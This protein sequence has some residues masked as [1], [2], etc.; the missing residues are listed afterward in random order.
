MLFPIRKTQVQIIHESN[1]YEVTLI[2]ICREVRLMSP[3]TLPG[4]GG[5]SR[6]PLRFSE[7]VLQSVSQ[8]VSKSSFVFV[9]SVRVCLCG[10]ELPGSRGAADSR[11]LRTAVQLIK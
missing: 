4:E 2:P 10:R 6:A 1:L 7:R 11:V 9:N 8:S 5:R 3:P